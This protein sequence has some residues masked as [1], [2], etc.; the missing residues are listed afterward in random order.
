MKYTIYSTL[1]DDPK[2]LIAQYPCLEVFGFETRTVSYPYK[3]KEYDA[4][5]GRCFERK[6]TGHKDVAYVTIDDLEK[7]T[8]L[9]A[10]LGCPIII[11]LDDVCDIEIYD[12]YRE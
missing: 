5:T 9:V 8:D 10:A 4:I 6:C 2:D 7:L 11:G 3:K 1:W 12:G